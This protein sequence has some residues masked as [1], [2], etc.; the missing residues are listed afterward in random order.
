MKYDRIISSS[1]LLL[2]CYFPIFCQIQQKSASFSKTEDE[3]KLQ[4]YFTSGEEYLNINR[5]AEGNPFLFNSDFV[6][7]VVIFRGSLFR[8][9]LLNYDVYNQFF[10]LNYENSLG[11]DVRVILPDEYIDSLYFGKLLFLPVVLSDGQIQYYNVH[12]SSGDLKILI[13]YKKLYKIS[14]GQSQ[15]NYQYSKLFRDFYFMNNSGIHKI[16]RISQL[17]KYLDQETI[18]RLKDYLKQFNVNLKKSSA[19]EIQ[20]LLTYITE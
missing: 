5:G 8:N 15:S 10:I 11:G 3:P 12:A 14:S 2:I 18:T 6:P 9:V 7:S 1:V 13:S 20:K 19:D 4:Q 16:N 17:H